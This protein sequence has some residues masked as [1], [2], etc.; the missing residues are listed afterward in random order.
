MRRRDFLGRA[1]AL[2]AAA[3]LA[4]SPLGAG[5]WSRIATAQ[6]KPLR[7]N[8]ARING[9]LA[10]MDSIGRTPGGINRVA[11]SEGD[12]AGRAFTMDLF[13]QAGLEPRID[14]AGNIVGRLEGSG[15]SLPPI[16]VGSH[17]DAVTDGGNFD[18]PLGS[19]GA[20]E[21]ARSL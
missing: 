2:A 11:Y 1:A 14:A 19:F 6:T 17:V 8:G 5:P 4:A 13:R 15:R 7:A 18:G 10:R 21:V 16:V 3:P 20:L 12:L 9:W